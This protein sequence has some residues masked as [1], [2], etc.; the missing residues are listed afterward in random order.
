[1]VYS[2]DFYR[3]VFKHSMEAVFL[4][5]PDGTILAANPAACK[6]FGRT[7][8]EICSVGRQGL[9]DASSPELSGF[10]AERARTGRA[11]AELVFIRGD[12]SRFSGET[13]SEQFFDD[14][15]NIRTILTVRD[16]T[17][18]KLAERLLAESE[19]QYRLLIT[20]MA[21]GVT[22]QDENSAIIAH[23]KS[24]ERI[25]GL[26]ADQLNG[27]TS[28]DP[29][30][31]AIHEDGSAFPGE[32]HPVV[33][34]LKTGLPQSDVIMG[35]HKPDGELTWISVNVQPIFKEGKT[36]PYRVVATMHDITERKAN[37]VKVRRISNLYAALSQ[38]NEAIVRSTSEEELF[39]KICRS[40]VQ[41]GGMKMV[42]IGFVDEAS[43]QV[44]P[45]ASYGAG[46][47]YLEELRLSTE[48]DDPNGR[49]P[50][51]TSI[52]ESRPFWCQDF[53]HDLATI[54]WHEHGVRFGW[55]ASASLPLYLNGV[56][57]G[58][59]TIYAD[60]VNAFDEAA[61]NLLV[62]MARD[63]SFALDN[64]DRERKRRQAQQALISSES[65]FRAYFERSMVGMAASSPEKGFLEVNEALCAILG[66][67]REELMRLTWGELTHPDDIADNEILFSRVHSGEI[68]EYTLDKRFIR[69][70][71]SF[72]YVHLAT[73]AVR[74]A[75]GR[76]DYMVA[77]IEDIT[78]RKKAEERIQ[79]LA[80]FD[81]LTGLPNR[82]LFA[83][84]F[85]HALSMAQRYH[86]QMAVLFL[87][88]DH[89]KNIN[90]TLGHSI[91]DALL[92]E[93]ALRLKSAVRE[94]DT[95]SRQGGDEFVLVLPD[96]DADGAAHVAEKL[97][98]A[99]AHSCQIEQY[100][101][102]ITSSI[103]IAMYPDDGENFELLYRGADIAMYRAKQDGRNNYRFFALEMQ[104]NS[105]RTLLLEN[106]LRHALERNQLRLHYQPQT[107]LQ[108]GRVIG[109]EALLRWQHP[110]LGAVSPAE[111]IPV[112]EA[113]GQILQIGEWVLRTAVQ[114]MKSWVDNGLEPMIIS[115]NLSSVQF[116]QADLPELVTQILAEEKLP[117]QYLELELTE[118]VAMSDPLGAI[119]MMDDL[120]QRG[121]RMSIDDFGTGYS[122][123]SYLKK[124][125]VYKLKI[126]QS[127][128]RDI[129]D[130]PEDK[131]IVAAIIS[132]AS[133]LGMQTIAEGVE[134]AGQLAFLRNQGC[135]EVQGYYF[136]KP[137]PAEQF[138][139]YVRGKSKA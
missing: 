128:V 29:R 93:V 129:T 94:E 66:Y 6:L 34:T 109:A 134:T 99:V 114:Q 117:P 111:F 28:L 40:A 88:L 132:L 32:T 110:E 87:D 96:I 24:A 62:E 85:N 74:F 79:Q 51:G 9:V 124:F 127:F 101:L 10:L 123:L 52:R 139:A 17:E 30:W 116:R 11:R 64:F 68:D 14:Q 136:S 126:D 80:Y 77:L 53:Q 60:E 35:I 27:R 33:M 122:S 65:H 137:L 98:K 105:A 67:S 95:V 84:R 90:D 56:V 4:T 44:K 8:E 7:E 76:L 38:C 89:F 39:P 50:T 22:L 131:A 113:S 83:D 26:T 48:A 119:A 16:L 47:E 125:K 86:T 75:D 42:W 100:E 107:S 115:V 23:N 130:D 57:I 54:P 97:R 31:Y 41:F 20:A 82:I 108:D 92:V 55:G 61:R 73:R 81:Q 12:G 121:I 69:K 49:G 13:S 135:N 102:N 45:V 3:S 106:A 1:V 72:V 21:E 46:E 133:S 15:Q 71:G 78:E 25:L 19:E 2:K 91:G 118:G 37:E 120:H 112:A 58:A 63:I 138:E 18:Y 59:F 104:A 70:D 36:T 43:R 103:G 5:A